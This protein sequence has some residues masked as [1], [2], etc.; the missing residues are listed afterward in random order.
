MRVKVLFF[1]FAHDLTGLREEQIEL[2]EGENLKGLRR[3]YEDRFPRLGELAGSLLFAV[4]QQIAEPLEILH[5]GDEVAFMPPVSGG[6]DGDIYRVT[7][8]RISASDLARSLQSPE[9]GA[10]V[11]FEGV[12]RNHS[13]GRKTLYLEYEAYTPMAIR[14]MEEIAAE[15]K[16]KFRINSVGI[17]HRT[18][19][20]EIGEISVAI[21]VTAAHRRP[22]FEA[23][24]YLIDRL[25]QVVPVWKKEYFEDGAVW[26]EGEGRKQV[27]TGTRD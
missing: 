23:C 9:D 22:A 14:K 4:N 26:V 3:S 6:I 8:E 12:V 25:K 24:Q 27:L 17:I 15:A 5:E 20:L 2:G 19:R 16:E 10:V 11:T 18:G 7:E 1:G 21:V 13:G